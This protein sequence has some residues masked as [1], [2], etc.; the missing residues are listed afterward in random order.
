MLIKVTNT[1]AIEI[2]LNEHMSFFYIQCQA[3]VCLCTKHLSVPT[4]ARF[5]PMTSAFYCLCPAFTVTFMLQ[6]EGII[7]FYGT[8]NFINFRILQNIFVKLKFESPRMQV[9]K[10]ATV[11]NEPESGSILICDT[12]KWIHNLYF[13]L[14]QTKAFIAVIS[15]HTS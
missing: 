9:I 8:T 6:N 1:I 14:W 13:L 5:W 3:L 10:I 7:L 4:S 2:D 12:K 11:P 15:R